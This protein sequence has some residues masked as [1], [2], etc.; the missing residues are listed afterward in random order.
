MKRFPHTKIMGIEVYSKTLDELQ[1]DEQQCVIGTANANTYAM[2]EKNAVYRQAILNADLV[3]AD[4]FPVVTAA[5]LLK[6]KRIQKIA[7]NDIFHFLLGNLQ[8][9]GGS[10][11]FL[12]AAPSTLEL[13]E[14]N[15]GTDYP[16]VRAGSFSPPYKAEFTEEDHLIMQEEVNRFKPDVLFVG[17]T[18]PKQEIWSEANRNK[19]DTKIIASIGAVFDFYAGTVKRPS[20]FW[21]KLNLE[22]FIRL[23][24]E[25]KRMWKR[26]LLNSPRF[27][28]LMLWAWISGSE[29]S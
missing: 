23:V 18:A 6:R 15:I 17:M 20:Q 12:G 29:T 21:I 19:L 11:F 9:E 22:W 1:F 24:K 14:K 4:G 27:F 26:Y 8:K 3:I 25:P 7:G 16:S 13:I 5:R 10:C 28:V 2:A